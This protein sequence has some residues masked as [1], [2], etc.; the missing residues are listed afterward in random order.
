MPFSLPI[1]AKRL[2]PK[3]MA[4]A[5]A[6]AGLVAMPA[7]Q[8]PAMAQVSALAAKAKQGIN[9]TNFKLDNGMEVVIIPDRRAP[10]VTHMV[11]YKAGSADE[12]PGKSGIAHYLEHLMFKGTKTVKGGEFSAK[13]SENGGQEN[14]FTSYDYTGYFQR[15]TPSLLGE[16]MRLEADRMENLVLTDEVIDP[17]RS[18]VLEERNSR[19]ENRPEGLF[20]EAMSAAMYRNHR[21]GVPIIGWRHEIEKLDKD[22]A[23]D[24]YDRFYTPNNA[25]LVVAGDVDPEEVRKLA[26]ETYGKV[27]RRA[28][29]GNRV[30]LSEPP[31]RAPHR[32]S[33]TH[34]RV[35]TP[36]WQRR[37]LVPSYYSAEGGEVGEELDLL[38]EIIGGGATSRIQRKIVIEDKIASSAGA[39]YQGSSKD[40]TTFGFYGTPRPG[41]TVEQLEAAIDAVIA[42]VRE[43]GVT[44]EE[45]DRAKKRLLRSTI[46][47][48][49]SQS[50]LARIYGASLAIG[51]TVEEIEKWPDDM[52]ATKLE[53][54]NAAA[55]KYLDINAS[56]T[57]TLSPAARKAATTE[58]PKEG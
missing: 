10:V 26:L 39:W 46:M 9:V 38:S 21:Y 14:A 16:M 37:Y 15:V 18:V 45:L 35:T 19:I 54:V 34:E 23:I 53:D 42:D 5:F 28:E 31:F 8:T 22:A 43:N 48:R 33:M 47:A 55:K 41:V 56:V 52:M 13:V 25:I 12:P 6:L 24:F 29:P 36:S 44:Q 40:D 27:A 11:W 4:L 58:Q 49:D 30:R 7:L 17:E 57:G 2:S 20:N 32:I 3:K 1:K 51:A 50:T